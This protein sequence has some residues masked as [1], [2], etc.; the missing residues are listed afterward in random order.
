MQGNSG[1]GVKD[2]I[3]TP[4]DVSLL[5]PCSVLTPFFFSQDKSSEIL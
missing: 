3:S 1:L 4:K 2:R 5:P